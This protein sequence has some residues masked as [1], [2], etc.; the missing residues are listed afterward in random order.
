MA[1]DQNDEDEEN[2][3]HVVV[4]ENPLFG[5]VPVISETDTT[6]TGTGTGTGLQSFFEGSTISVN[7][8]AGLLGL[9]ISSSKATL[10]PYQSKVLS[11]RDGSTSTLASN[12]QNKVAGTQAHSTSTLYS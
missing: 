10:G 7:G 3:F 11:M 1:K 9:G 8:A 2:P 12:Y 6:G 4:F 5:D